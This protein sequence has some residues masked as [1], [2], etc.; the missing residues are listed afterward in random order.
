MTLVHT[1][2]ALVLAMIVREAPNVAANS[3]LHDDFE[4]DIT[5]MLTIHEKV[6]QSGGLVDAEFDMLLLAAVNYRE[7]RMRLP[8]PDGDCGWS[9]KYSKVPSGLWPVGYKPVLKYVCTSVGPMQVNRGLVYTI[10]SWNEVKHEFSERLWGGWS[11]VPRGTKPDRLT[12]DQLREPETNVRIAYAILQHWKYECMDR[13]G[14]LAPAGVWLTAYRYGKCPHYNKGHGYH[15]DK[16][17]KK[18]CEMANGWAESLA[19]S[20]E[21][22][23][24]GTSS[25]SCTYKDR[26]APRE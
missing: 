6:A 10:T 17:A 3:K 13:D 8:A 12:E 9:H 1:L 24:T 14:G 15:I 5:Q 19:S 7:N 18:R 22:N 21:V 25:M 16:E 11:E 23:Y 20:D 26:V 4:S 2:A